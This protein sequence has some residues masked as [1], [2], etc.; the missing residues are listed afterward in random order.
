MLTD[1]K[2]SNYIPLDA[3]WTIRMGFRDAMVQQKSYCINKLE[4]HQAKQ[5]LSDDLVSLKKVLYSL[6][7]AYLNDPVEV[8]SAKLY[9]F[10]SWFLMV[11]NYQK[12]IVKSEN[13]IN[14]KIVDPELKLNSYSY[15]S[16]L[17]FDGETGEYASV[18]G[19]FNGLSKKA[20]TYP[21]HLKMT[22]DANKHW[23][24]TNG[25][26]MAKL[27]NTILNQVKHLLDNEEFEIDRPEYFAYAYLFDML[28]LEDAEKTW[29]QLNRSGFNAFKEIVEQKQLLLDGSTIDSLNHRTVE[30]LVMYAL[31]NDLDFKVSEQSKLVVNKN[32]P[33]F[34][35]FV[36]KL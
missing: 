32:W 11:N 4:I 14:R 27:D 36:E 19:L 18:K 29:P 15:S 17:K 33:S 9:R 6:K 31:K 8:D 1:Y 21:Y 28:S 12:D 10:L 34:W 13:L 23:E 25:K 35:N 22:V 24:A 16:L 2:L 5:P 3:S 20:K 30:A 26:W 7:T